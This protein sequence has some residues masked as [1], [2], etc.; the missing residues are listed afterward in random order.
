MI[1]LVQSVLLAVGDGDSQTRQN[2]EL[3][4][5]LDKIGTLDFDII[6]FAM[7]EEAL[8]CR[9]RCEFEI[10]LVQQSVHSILILQEWNACLFWEVKK[11]L[12]SSLAEGEKA[13]YAARQRR[14][15]TLGGPL[16][17]CD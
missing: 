14:Y 8:L 10:T 16:Q 17:E 13:S 7:F 12:L 1:S 6:D 3:R 4:S 11:S 5:A 2:V 15:P 9:A